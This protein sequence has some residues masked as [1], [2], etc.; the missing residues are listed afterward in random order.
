M[1]V[2]VAPE[3]VEPAAVEREGVPAAEAAVRVGVTLLETAASGGG[4]TV[5][6]A[7]HRM[8][9]V[10]GEPQPMGDLQSADHRARLG[11]S[12]AAAQHLP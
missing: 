5:V 4:G 11:A 1:V 3:T 7:D 6:S 12:A 8:R 10:I 2:A 9:L